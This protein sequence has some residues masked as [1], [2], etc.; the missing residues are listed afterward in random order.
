M[1]APLY[2]LLLVGGKSTRMGQDKAQLIYR[3]DQPEWIR[4]HS[5]L[6]A[7]CEKSFLSHRAD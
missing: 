4:L 3:D 7:H 6:N 5:L 1:A 2:G